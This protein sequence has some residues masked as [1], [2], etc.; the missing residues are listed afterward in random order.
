VTWLVAKGLK[1]GSSGLPVSA[2]LR[3]ALTK[4]VVVAGKSAPHDGSVR[5]KRA[6]IRHTGGP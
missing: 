3:Q 4:K 6:D 5:G 1:I 2:V